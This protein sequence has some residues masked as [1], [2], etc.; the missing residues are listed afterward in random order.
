MKRNLQIWPSADHTQPP[1]WYYVQVNHMRSGG[2]VNKVIG[3]LRQISELKEAILSAQRVMEE[4]EREK[5]H[6]AQRL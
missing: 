1:E 2:R 3:T 4:A 5:R 6:A